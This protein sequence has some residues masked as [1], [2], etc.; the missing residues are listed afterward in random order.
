MRLKREN[1]VIK[2]E[3]KNLFKNKT[4]FEG[5]QNQKPKYE[6]NYLQ[7]RIKRLNINHQKEK[8]KEKNL[9]HLATNYLINNSN[10]YKPNKKLFSNRIIQKDLEKNNIY[11]NDIK[12]IS[13]IINNNMNIDNKVN[14][15]ANTNHIH[16]KSENNV[17]NND[18]SLKNRLYNDN[19]TNNDIDDYSYN[20]IDAIHYNRVD[21][22][23]NEMKKEKNISVELRKRKI[24]RGAMTLDYID[25]INDNENQKISRINNPIY[26][27][28]YKSNSPNSINNNYKYETTIDFRQNL[29]S[30]RIGEIHKN[31]KYIN[32]KSQKMIF[33]NGFNKTNSN[34][35][36]MNRNHLDF[37]NENKFINKKE[38]QNKTANNFFVNKNQISTARH[39]NNNYFNYINSKNNI[40]LN[41]NLRNRQHVNSMTIETNNQYT[42]FDGDNNLSYLN[43]N[44]NEGN[45]TSRRSKNKNKIKINKNN[46]SNIVE[47]N[48]D[49]SDIIDD[50]NEYKKEF[51]IRKDHN[52]YKIFNNINLKKH[53]VQQNF[54]FTKNIIPIITTQFSIEGI[55]NSF[56]L[57]NETNYNTKI[58]NLTNNN[59]SN[60]RK[61]LLN[62]PK[63][64]NS[65]NGKKI[66]HFNNNNCNREGNN[67]INIEYDNISC[68]KILFKK[69]PKNEIPKPSLLNKRKNSSSS[70]NS[71]SNK[72]NKKFDKILE[73]NKIDNFNINPDEDNNKLCFN[74]EKEIVNYIN[75]KYEDEKRKSY[76]NKKFRFTGFV[77]SKKYKGNNLYD[78]RIEDDLDKIN[79]QLKQEKVII[80]NKQV[81]LI[82]SDNND[83][84]RNGL[85]E[86]IKILKKENEKLSKKEIAQND[87]IIKL[88]KEKQKLMVEI[89]NMKKNIEESN[90][91][92]SKLNKDIDNK[93]NKNIL[94]KIENNCLFSINKSINKKIINKNDIINIK[95]NNNKNNYNNRLDINKIVYDLIN[96]GKISEDIN[97]INKKNNIY[98][99]SDNDINNIKELN[100]NKKILNLI[101]GILKLDEINKKLN[102]K[103]E[104][105]INISSVNETSINDMEIYNQSHPRIN[106][107]VE[108]EMS[109]KEE[110]K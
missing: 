11:L 4:L 62:S 37:I 70:F 2:N 76:F 107:L 21:K 17:K 22:K 63:R 105:N 87:L 24:N 102:L 41:R 108:S 106:D 54:F 52:K 59:E 71:N 89:E 95:A 72:S 91:I 110:L 26:S 44:V 92:I 34:Y 75:R 49:I 57:I 3:G 14:L 10:V 43:N 30:D 74:S 28:I 101:D 1:P 9:N 55:K 36:N 46:N 47:Y 79:Y 69:R 58:N 8:L 67:D 7:N 77:L 65:I 12:E 18:N 48:L 66:S 83:Y 6:N 88:D 25:E 35:Y 61:H 80:N 33:N 16:I 78:I 94:L 96:D 32:E 5:N 100:N 27:K 84:S 20:T 60:P 38:A 23:N 73:I 42:S 90:N 56:N 98:N 81:E 68:N 50:T 103:D 45:K 39:I 15:L 104:D 40:N 53:N 93:M 82:F 51:N 97:N 64:S 99:K 29:L 13:S 19:I 109:E 86:E 31:N 85:E